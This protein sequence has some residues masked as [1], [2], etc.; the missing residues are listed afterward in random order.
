M[1]ESEHFTVAGF[2]CRN[3]ARQ[4]D[5][6]AGR[7][8]GRQAAEGQVPPLTWR[9][10]VRTS[11]TWVPC[12]RVAPAST[13]AAV[14]THAAIASAGT[15]TPIRRRGGAGGSIGVQGSGLVGCLLEVDFAW[16]LF[17]PVKWSEWVSRWATEYMPPVSRV[18]TGQVFIGY[19]LAVTHNW[20]LA[21]PST[22]KWKKVMILCRWPSLI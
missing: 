20:V 19:I 14:T 12:L 17:G 2:D 4:A 5:R 10:M 11:V 3:L 13:P 16:G 15:G 1:Y 18:V 6:Q 22:Y 21:S 8:A 9:W 7:Q